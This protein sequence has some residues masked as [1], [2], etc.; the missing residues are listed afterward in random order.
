MY[1]DPSVARLSIIVRTL[2]MIELGGVNSGATGSKDVRTLNVSQWMEEF[3]V[4]G[5]MKPA[6]Q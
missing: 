2:V 6:G 4:S 5:P 3:V 1:P